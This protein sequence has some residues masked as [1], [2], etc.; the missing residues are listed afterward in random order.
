MSCGR[1]ACREG[2]SREVLDEAADLD[3]EIAELGDKVGEKI[4]R[5][6]EGV[7]SAP[8]KFGDTLFKWLQWYGHTR[9]DALGTYEQY[10]D[11]RG[12]KD[13]EEGRKAYNKSSKELW[14]KL[15]QE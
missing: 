7:C 11:D 14:D 10:L 6:A 3:D 13:N 15:Y 2:Y 8:G 1:K 4:A 12:F 5:C 9:R